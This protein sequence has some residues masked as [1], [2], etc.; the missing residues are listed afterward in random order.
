VRLLEKRDVMRTSMG[1]VEF[2]SAATNVSAYD[3][4]GYKWQP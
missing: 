2:G 1:V 3:D 4:E